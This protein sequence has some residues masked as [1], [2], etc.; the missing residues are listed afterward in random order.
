MQKD[1]WNMRDEELERLAKECSIS[2]WRH[3][4]AR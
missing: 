3:A 2:T 4:P 1:Y